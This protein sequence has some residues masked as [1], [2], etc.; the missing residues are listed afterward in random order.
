MNTISN[1]LVG[2]APGGVTPG[3]PVVAGIPGGGL[4]LEQYPVVVRAPAMLARKHFFSGLGRWAGPLGWAAGLGRG[5]WGAAEVDSSPTLVG[6]LESP[7]IHSFMQQT[8]AP[9]P[10]F[11]AAM[12]SAASTP[13]AI[14]ARLLRASWE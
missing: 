8:G 11:P 10:A 3:E 6:K 1:F 4:L 13:A 2:S 12:T 5:S 9:T 7:E 14:T